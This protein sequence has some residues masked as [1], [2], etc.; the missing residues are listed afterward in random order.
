LIGNSRVARTVAETRRGCR[1][2]TSHVRTDT[3]CGDRRQPLGLSHLRINGNYRST[4]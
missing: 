2:S 3:R 4:I 1:R